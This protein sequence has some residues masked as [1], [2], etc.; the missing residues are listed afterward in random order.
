MNLQSSVF[1]TPAICGLLL[2]GAKSAWPTSSGPT[3]SARPEPA[4][5]YLSVVLPCR[6]HGAY[7][8]TRRTFPGDAAALPCRGTSAYSTTR[9]TLP[10]DAVVLPWCRGPGSY[11]VRPCAR[12]NH[13]RQQTLHNSPDRTPLRLT[14]FG[15][16]LS[17]PRFPSAALRPPAPAPAPRAAPRR[18]P[19]SKASRCASWTR[20]PSSVPQM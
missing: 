11:G 15:Y 8:T 14:P 2:H 6:G 9:R 16:R 18:A 4:E 20:A 5:P 10:G 13:R 12:E 1:A 19:S 7:S 17:P 3:A